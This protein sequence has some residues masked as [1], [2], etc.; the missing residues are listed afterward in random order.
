MF[1]PSCKSLSDSPIWSKLILWHSMC[2]LLLKSSNRIL[3]KGNSL[4]RMSIDQ[5]YFCVALD[6]VDFVNF[7]NR[8]WKV[9][10]MWFIR[11]ALYLGENMWWVQLWVISGQM[12]HVRRPWSIWRLL[13]QRVHTHRKGC[14]YLQYYPLHEFVRFCTAVDCLSQIYV[15]LH[16]MEF[17]PNTV[18]DDVLLYGPSCHVCGV[19]LLMVNKITINHQN[20][21]KHNSYYYMI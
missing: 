6:L 8:W 2:R 14:M 19:F 13:L 5:K 12:C 20:W 11:K 4:F 9:C 18:L 16:D 21:C 10:N 3:H 15:Q 7:H 17:Y 1:W